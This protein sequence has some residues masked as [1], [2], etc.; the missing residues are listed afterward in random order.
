MIVHRLIAKRLLLTI[1]RLATMLASTGRRLDARNSGS[2][3]D[4]RF[5]VGQLTAGRVP[6][7]GEGAEMAHTLRAATGGA[8]R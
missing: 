2:S 3:F 7:S 4:A 8:G 5:D 6:G 1:D